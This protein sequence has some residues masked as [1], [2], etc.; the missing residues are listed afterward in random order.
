M[1]D[2]PF[3]KL[4]TEEAT[5]L[6]KSCTRGANSVEEIRERLTEAGFNGAAAAISSTRS[7]PM[8]MAMVMVWGPNGES[9][10]A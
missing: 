9:I 6:A 7:G 1:A 8:F 2:K 5:A 4:T 3:H 10:S